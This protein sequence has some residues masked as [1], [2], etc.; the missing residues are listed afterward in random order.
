MRTEKR[1]RSGWVY[2]LTNPA[3]PG[4]VKVGCTGDAPEIR[5]A[6]LSEKTA[7]PQPFA[8]AWAVP[9]SDWYGVEALSHSW[10]AEC[11][12]NRNREFFRCSVGQAR[13]AV[14]RSARAYL[15]PAWLRLLIGP[16]RGRG[17]PPPRRA[18]RRGDA[19]ALLAVGLV[20]AAVVAL[21]WFKPPVPS[22]VPSG[23]VV[24]AVL[25]VERG[26]F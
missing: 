17:G 24:R 11:R 26:K 12:P 6:R 25:L 13:R 18:Y 14:E 3:M 23:P 10:L 20:V 7:A 4:L 1:R 8:V 9:V 22:W 19:S 2:I 21:A 16:R 5:A 15:R